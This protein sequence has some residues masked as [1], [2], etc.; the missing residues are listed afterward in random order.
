MASDVKKKKPVG[1][2]KVK[3][4]VVPGSAGA[5]MMEELAE[6]LRTALGMA[7]ANQKKKD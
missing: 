5:R 4:V 1:S 2:P 6:Q 3:D 7:K